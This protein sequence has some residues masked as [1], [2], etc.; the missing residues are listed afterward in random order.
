[1]I[2]RRFPV[3][4]WETPRLRLRLLREADLEAVTATCNDPAAQRY[5]TRLPHPYTMDDAREF[6]TGPAAEAWKDGRAQWVIADLDSDEYLGAIGVPRIQWAF[7]T[8]EIGYLVAPWARGRGVAAEATASVADFLFSHGISRTELHI[9]PDNIASQKA[10]LRAGFT[11]DALLRDGIADRDGVRRGRIVYGRL[12]YDPPGPVPRA[13]PDLPRGRLSD[14]VVT[15]R[16]LEA[17]DAQAYYAHHRK[18]EIWHTSVPAVPPVWE[19]IEQ[20]CR[21]L[22]ADQWLAG[23]AARMTIRDAVTDELAGSI[24]VHPIPGPFG[25]A[26]I[27][28]GLDRAFW[29]RGMA[30][31]AVRLLARWAFQSARVRRLTAGTAITNTAS[32]AVLARVG[33][34]REGV[35]RKLLPGPD[36]QLT[37]NVSWCLLPEEFEA[38]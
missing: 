3:G 35:Q 31:R 6:L 11:R 18:P 9:L 32:Q 17:T 28:Y 2:D 20:L 15:L 1:M 5:L 27:G 37:D 34:S 10:A 26:M 23:K 22:A 24:L 36:G 38:G 21:F 12:S 19:Q 8:A 14:G 7:E 4:D 16:P 25:E 30:T 29:G 13:L 33:F